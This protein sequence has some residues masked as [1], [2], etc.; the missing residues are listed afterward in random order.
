MKTLMIGVAL[1]LAAPSFAQT[2][3]PQG[4]PGMDAPRGDR[5]QGMRGNGG[6]RGRMF[7]SMTPE[8]R[9][10]MGEA[11][12]GQPQDRDAV[13]AAR[14]RITGLVAADRLDVP[15]LKRAMDEERRLVDSQHARRQTALI[16]GFQKLTLADRKAFAQD[17]RKG[18]DAMEA[19][20]ARW[21]ERAAAPGM[22]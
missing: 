5:P 14:D 18:R 4:S 6:Q 17:A 21:R 22:E 10:I 8:G 1:L 9:A 11:L 16:A 15:A 7:G 20:A 3:P 19:R 2:P 13:K 12:R